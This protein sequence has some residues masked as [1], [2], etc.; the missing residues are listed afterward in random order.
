MKN[1]IGTSVIL[2]IFGESHGAG[3]G[4]VLD[5]LAPG[6]EVD[7]EFIASQL[8]RRKGK[9]SLSTG[10]REKDEVKILSGVFNGKTTGTPIAFLIENADKKSADYDRL[11]F[12][13]RPSHADYAAQLKYRGF[14]DYRGGGHFSG[15]ITAGIVA[16]ASL[17]LSARE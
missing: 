12:V 10:R 8:E 15:R 14:Q 2:T 11:R 6:I 4:A 9:S 16:A 3:I 13:A 5:G 7:E 1:S 17:C